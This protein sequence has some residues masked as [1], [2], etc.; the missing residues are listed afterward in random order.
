MRQVHQV[1][2]EEVI[3]LQV[4]LALGGAQELEHEKV[5]VILDRGDPPV[6]VLAWMKLTVRPHRQPHE[7]PE[8]PGFGREEGGGP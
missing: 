7:I 4:S 6:E 2:G 3:A 5:A 8:P 1:R